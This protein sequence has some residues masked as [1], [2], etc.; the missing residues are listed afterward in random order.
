[1]TVEKLGRP[2]IEVT[3]VTI[4]EAGRKVLV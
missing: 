1:V 4:T 3:R 2:A